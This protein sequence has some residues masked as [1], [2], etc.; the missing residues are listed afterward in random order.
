MP[1]D[2]LKAGN[3]LW[4]QSFAK[5]NN[6]LLYDCRYFGYLFLIKSARTWPDNNPPTTLILV[7]NTLTTISESNC[8]YLITLLT[9]FSNSVRLFITTSVSIASINVRVKLPVNRLLF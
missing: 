9:D 1:V 3:N 2:E 6:S 7:S 8:T 4:A 5:F